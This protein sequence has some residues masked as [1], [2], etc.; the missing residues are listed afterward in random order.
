MRL[1]TRPLV[2]RDLV[3]SDRIPRHFFGLPDPMK[4]FGDSN[5]AHT[6]FR[7]APD[8]VWRQKAMASW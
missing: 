5:P 6:R 2:E 8:S 3:E 4:M 7:A 1:R